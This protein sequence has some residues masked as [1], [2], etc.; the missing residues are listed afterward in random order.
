MFASE[1]ITNVSL[2]CFGG[3]L[4]GF[5]EDLLPVFTKAKQTPGWL[6][7]ASNGMALMDETLAAG[8]WQ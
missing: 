5:E 2:V 6:D 4:G 3:F 1:V 7:G 8:C